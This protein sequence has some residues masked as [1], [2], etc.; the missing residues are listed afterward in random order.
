MR[1]G[2]V[3]LLAAMFLI[4]CFMDSAYAA[5]KKKKKKKKGE[6]EMV[7][8][9]PKTPQKKMSPYEKLFRG[10]PH[11]EYKGDFVTVH[12]VGGKIYFGELTFYPS[13]GLGCFTPEEW[14]LRLGELI[15]LDGKN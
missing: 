2:L 7:A 15:K 3:F 10:K 12:R 14:D 11:Q 9:K 6:V 4:P 13:A 1:K 5:D 8:A